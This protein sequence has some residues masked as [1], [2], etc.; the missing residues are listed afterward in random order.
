MRTGNRT[1]SATV[2]S[3]VRSRALRI[4]AAA[5]AASLAALL[6][7][8]A[9]LT[10]RAAGSQM[11]EPERYDYV[12]LAA[13]T[14]GI[15]LGAQ[16]VPWRREP[17][18]ALLAMLAGAA[19][20]FSAIGAFS[21]GLAFLPAGFV[22]LMLLYR[23]VRRR[24]LAAARPAALGGA[25]VGYASVLLLIAQ[26]VPPTAQCFPNGAGSSGPRWNLPQSVRSS[27]GGGP[28]GVFTGRSEFPDSIVTFRCEGGRL[29]E[30]QR[31]AR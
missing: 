24:D 19:L 13:S 29:V 5:T 22:L 3:L 10:L 21:I 31:V 4:V 8:P 14:F 30:F 15:A 25:L 7:F 11:F 27:G 2:R 26:G 16:L 28:G 20:L 12:L 1:A 17:Y 18:V 6:L 23:A 9:Y